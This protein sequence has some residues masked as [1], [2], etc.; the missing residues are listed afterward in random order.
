MPLFN[1]DTGMVDGFCHASLEDECLK[2]AFKK[3]FHSEGQHIIKLVL[4]LIQQTIS[5][6]PPHKGLTLENPAWVFLLE[7][8]K[9]S[10]CITDAAESILHPPELPFA[11]KT[12]LTYEFQF[13]IQSFLFIRTTGL[14]ESLSI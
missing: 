1:E 6:H 14:L 13:S 12:I 2:A 11:S 5:V 7:G 10:C 3:V 4:A 9:H 8:Q